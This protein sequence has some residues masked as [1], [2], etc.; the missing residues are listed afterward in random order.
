[1][2]YT[3]REIINRPSYRNGLILGSQAKTP[4]AVIYR[5]ASKLAANGRRS[6]I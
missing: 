3:T 1:M 6:G 5:Y 2:I 4:I